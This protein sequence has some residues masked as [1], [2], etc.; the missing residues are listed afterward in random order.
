MID[1]YAVGHYY[2][3]VSARHTFRGRVVWAGASEIVI[4]DYQTI[5]A[6]GRWTT[7]GAPVWAAELCSEQLILG[8]GTV[9]YAVE[10]LP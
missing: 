9:D 7:P 8:R 10:V 1:V 5:G 6:A 2:I 3:F 4:D